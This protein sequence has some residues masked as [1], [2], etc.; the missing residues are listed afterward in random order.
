M[1]PPF[2]RCERGTSAVEFALLSPFF[3]LFILGMTAYG[4]YLGAS[5]SVRQI[6]ADAARTAVAGVDLTERRALVDGFVDG[7]S[8]AYPFI[9]RDRMTVSVTGNSADPRRFT[10]SVRYDAR[11]L[12]VWGLFR[13]I[14]M[15]G[16]TIVHSSTILAGGA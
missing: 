4:I 6:A 5:H 10:V 14:P 3:L 8:D 12:P 11:D 1:Q 16:R 7:Q 9:R 15:P 2:S 13:G